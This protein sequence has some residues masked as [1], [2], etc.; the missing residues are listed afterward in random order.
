MTERLEDLVARKTTLKRSG[1]ELKGLCPFHE[2][3]TPSFSVNPEKQV[4]K[5][6]G[7]GE[8]GSLKTWLVKV[9]GWSGKRA[10]AAVNGA[11]KTTM[12]KP[13]PKSSRKKLL[14]WKWLKSNAACVAHHIYQGS[15][16]QP[17]F[18]ILR[19]DKDLYKQSGQPMRWWGKCKPYH[20]IE[21]DGR[22]GWV[23][24]FPTDDAR[25]LY[26]LPKLLEA[27]DDAQ[28]MVVE[29]EKCADTVSRYFPDITVT[30]NAGGSKS[31]ERTDWTPV[32]GRPV[33]VVAD[34]DA[35]GRAWAKAVAGQLH[36]QG[37]KVRMVLPKGKG[38]EDIHDWLV[39]G[40]RD[41]ALGILKT[42]VPYE[43]KKTRAER[44]AEN[45]AEHA[46]K[47]A[48]AERPPNLED[49]RESRGKI[50]EANEHF[51][52][53][54]I[55]GEQVA[56]MLSTHRIVA[57]PRTSLMNSSTLIALAPLSWWLDLFDKPSL[58]NAICQ[59]VGSALIRFAD[60]KGIIDFKTML[61]RGYCRTLKGRRV[62]NL[63]DRLMD[64][65]GR[66]RPL[67]SMPGEL[68]A[69]AGP[70]IGLHPRKAT[71]DQTRAF[72]ESL[73]G[74]RWESPNDGRIF[75]GWIICAIIG[76][77][78]DWRPHLWLIAPPETGKSWIMER[79][80]APVLG[81]MAVSVSD[82]SSAAVARRMGSDAIA[83]LHDEFEPDRSGV[84]GVLDIIR[85]AAGGFGERIRAQ[86][87][88]AVHSLQPRFT[89][90]LSS[91]KMAQ[92]SQANISRF[93]FPRLSMT[94][95][96]DW[97]SV[98]KAIASALADDLPDR[99]RTAAMRD[100][101]SIVGSIDRIQEQLALTTPMST[102][103]TMI[104]AAL[105]GCW[106]WLTGDSTLVVPPDAEAGEGDMNDAATL[107]MDILGI[108]MRQ[109]DGSD[110]SM[111]A[112]LGK[113]PR[114]R[115]AM[116]YGVFY[117]EGGLVIAPGHPSL[118]KTMGR[119]RW[120]GIEMRQTLLQIRGATLTPSPVSFP[121]L[122][123]YRCVVIPQE[124]L[125]RIGIEWQPTVI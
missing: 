22:T 102:R 95:V 61:G 119:S 67:G 53:L 23:A 84:E 110:A 66:F 105:S 120:R 51:S 65:Q 11:G 2:E 73:L 46:R 123:R 81:P 103:K 75:A 6:F 91:V 55:L 62:W 121:G 30:C 92:T 101:R 57:F 90:A 49:P 118:R 109:D 97:P 3:K 32:R 71:P 1:A 124:A 68:L 4:Y 27:P 88:T 85:I 48:E 122:L 77:A 56:F 28:V 79:V 70:P 83:L 112:V 20:R 82:S 40:G 24:G 43:K 29:G 38:G 80:A 116:D 125:E 63:G 100:A 106:Q 54:G 21:R 14:D 87:H 26:R 36:E 60:Q 98:S 104:F 13:K 25:P 52:V 99:I 45:R 17:A 37:C 19:Y 111:A 64:P 108:R 16:G 44:K 72:A 69:L 93:V 39:S 58:T 41:R 117:G 33:M 94:P 76:G 86:G 96:E 115:L 107:V 5:C 10:A 59:P 78:L 113:S 35:M 9:E 47:R 15:D 12:E 7:C 50:L 8:S 114:D 42:W 89:A 34:T 31:W 18:A 74:Y